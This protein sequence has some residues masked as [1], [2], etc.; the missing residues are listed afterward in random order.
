MLC[1]ESLA[2]PVPCLS[3]LAALKLEITRFRNLKILFSFDYMNELTPSLSYR[4]NKRLYPLLV[5]VV[6]VRIRR[7]PSSIYTGPEVAILQYLVSNIIPLGLIIV[8]VTAATS[9]GCSLWPIKSMRHLLYHIPLK[10]FVE[11]VDQESSRQ[12]QSSCQSGAYVHPTSGGMPNGGK[13]V[14]PLRFQSS[15]RSG[16]SAL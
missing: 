8:I 6:I 10:Y 13:C 3:D 12:F 2:Y 16:P 4:C 11:E 14:F 1:E 7:N 15:T 9:R 5:C